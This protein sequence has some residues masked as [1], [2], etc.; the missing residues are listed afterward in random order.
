MAVASVYGGSVSRP[1]TDQ[2]LSAR[3][4]RPW[5]AGRRVVNSGKSC[6]RGDCRSRSDRSRSRHR[7]T[8]AEFPPA[9]AQSCSP[10]EP[11]QSPAVQI[12]DRRNRPGLRPVARR[13]Y[14]ARQPALGAHKYL[15]LLRL[16]QAVSESPMLWFKGLCA[17]L[18]RI[19]RCSSML[20]F[21]LGETPC[22]VLDQLPDTVLQSDQYSMEPPETRHSGNHQSRMVFQVN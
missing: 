15:L 19:A 8:A 14:P 6:H 20:T 11:H 7:G 16:G 17:V 4:A 9:A 22:I 21:S 10:E 2:A 18:C 5:Q 13:R 3:P 1:V 12:P